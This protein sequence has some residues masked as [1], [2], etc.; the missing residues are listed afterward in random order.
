MAGLL[1]DMR[2]GQVETLLILDANPVYAMPGFRE[3][4]RRVKFS[5]CTA[6]APNETAHG[7]HM[8]R[9]GHACFRDLGR[10]ARA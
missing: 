7:G 8:A 4:L 5:L 10:R 6:P 9:S 3:A 2:A 1:D